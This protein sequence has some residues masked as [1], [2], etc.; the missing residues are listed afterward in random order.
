MISLKE[1]VALS[2]AD[3]KSS[4]GNIH[5]LYLFYVV[6]VSWPLN[7]VINETINYISLAGSSA[8]IKRLLKW[9]YTLEKEEIVNESLLFAIEKHIIDTKMYFGFCDWFDLV[10]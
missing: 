1:V 5:I 3:S 4:F 10:L 9:L 7:D 2:L 6:D 8:D